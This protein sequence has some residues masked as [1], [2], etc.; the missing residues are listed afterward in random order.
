MDPTDN[1]TVPLPRFQTAV[2][3]TLN[4]SCLPRF[5]KTAG[6]HQV[7]CQVD[8]EVYNASCQFNVSVSFEDE[9]PETSDMLP[10]GKGFLSKLNI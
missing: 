2:N 3:E 10:K 6:L 4:V 9:V 8:D 5:V 7:L 1:F